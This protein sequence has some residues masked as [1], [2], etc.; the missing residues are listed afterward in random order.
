[1][2][3][4]INKEPNLT[5]ADLSPF[6]GRWVALSG[7][8][9]VGVGE[10][11]PAAE[12][13]GRRNRI[14]DQL[15]IY[16]VEPAGGVPLP[17]PP[18]LDKLQ[19][20]FARLDQPV[21]LVGGAI[22]DMLLGRSSK[23][24]DFVLPSG[25]VQLAFKVADFLGQPAYVLDRQRDAGRIVLQREDTTLDFT[26]FR[27]DD[28]EAD[29]RDRDFCLNTLAL[30]VA[31]K[32]RASIVDPCRGIE[33]IEK[34]RIRLTHSSALKDDPVRTLRA[35]RLALELDF[36]LTA[37]TAAAI[38]EA[39]PLLENVSMERARDELLKMFQ[40][41]EPGRSLSS[42]A[43][44]E[45]L[46]IILPE[47]NALA[48]VQQ[49]AP[50]HEPVLDHV[51][52]TL[53]WLATVERVI[54]YGQPAAD[55]RL[56]VAQAHL[57]NFVPSLNQHFERRVDGGL[58]GYLILRLGALFHDVGKASTQ[59]VDPDGHIRFYGHDKIGATTVGR[60]LSWLKLSKEAI[61]GVKS[62]VAG[63]MR[64]LFLSQ[65]PSLSRRAIYRFY[66]DHG[67]YG[68]DICL[69][70]LADHLAIYDRMDGNLEWDRL[71]NVVDQLIGHYFLHHEDSVRPNPLIDGQDL[72]DILQ[73]EPGP[74]IG[75][76]LRL[77]EEAQAAGEITTRDQALA[78]A[79]QFNKS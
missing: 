69:L 9:V 46:P 4:Q 23:D 39:A 18:L 15:S 36:N 10:T 28:L 30:P 71:L 7:D 3:S 40:L 77:I 25:A 65:N 64:P 19:P 62:I 63:H 21:Y 54:L 34:R 68:L 26:R 14:R 56:E 66:R 52:S 60:A 8:Q 70:S 72:I 1:M 42:L 50:H 17:L 29:L 43:E 44:L 6:V 49:S 75:R 37:E 53:R 45:L 41:P 27:G 38:K 32:S 67:A 78:L 55:P 35:I 58:D 5:N 31:A 79:R 48:G 13:L 16:Y 47:I 73:V 11:A 74:E 61:Y 20:I 76:L 51:Q 59:E 22:R 57:T 12:R 2:P 24:L 33:D